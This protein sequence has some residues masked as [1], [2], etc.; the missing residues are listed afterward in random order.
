MAFI[1]ALKEAVIDK[2]L[3]LRRV[4]SKCICRSGRPQFEIVS[5]QSRATA[6]GKLGVQ[7]V[8][9]VARSSMTANATAGEK[10]RSLWSSWPIAQG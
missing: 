4:K 6:M 8:I 2:K 5:L 7:H 3:D 10:R 9:I 1:N